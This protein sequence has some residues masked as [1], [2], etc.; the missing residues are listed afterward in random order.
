MDDTWNLVMLPI[1]Q[2]T[3][4]V[5]ESLLLGSGSPLRR[6]KGKWRRKADGSVITVIRRDYNSKRRRNHFRVY[7]YPVRLWQLLQFLLFSLLPSTVELF[8]LKQLKQMLWWIFFSFLSITRMNRV[9]TDF[10][11][12]MFIVNVTS[13]T[14]VYY[15]IQYIGWCVCVYYVNRF[16]KLI[17]P[18]RVGSS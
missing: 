1:M 4:A 10:K 7:R 18:S 6:P 2:L 8:P 3:A 9:G 5:V 14:V 11:R 12:Q 13:V 15:Y 17:E 16:I